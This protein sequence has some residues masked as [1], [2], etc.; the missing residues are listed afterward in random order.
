MKKYNIYNFAA[1]L[2]FSTS[3]LLAMEGDGSE[4]NEMRKSLSPRSS[5]EINEYSNFAFGVKK[6]NEYLFIGKKEPGLFFVM[7]RVDLSVPN[8]RLD[9]WTQYVL[10]EK[11]NHDRYRQEWANDRIPNKEGFIRFESRFQ[12]LN[13]GL[14]SFESSVK[15]HNL[16]N[17]LWIAY[18]SAKEIQKADEITPDDVEMM[19]TILTDKD[20]PMVIHMGITRC[21]HYLLKAMETE[22]TRESRKKLTEEQRQER[23]I[24]IPSEDEFKLHGSLSMGLHSFA[25][26]V[27][28]IRDEKKLYMITAPVPKMTEIMLK[29]LPAHVYVGTPLQIASDTYYN[30]RKDTDQILQSCLIFEE[31][32]KLNSEMAILEK[33]KIQIGTEEL[34]NEIKEKKKESDVLYADYR[35][36]QKKE[37]QEIAETLEMTKETSPIKNTYFPNKFVIFDKDRKHVVFEHDKDSRTI[38]VNNQEITGD[39]TKRYDWFYHTDMPLNPY[40]TINLDALSACLKLSDPH[41]SALLVKSYQPGEET[42]AED[43]LKKG[44]DVNAQDDGGRTAL[45]WA[46]TVGCYDDQEHNLPMIK[47][48]LA[49]KADPNKATPF[50][51]TPL[52][53]AAKSGHIEVA[54]LLLEAGAKVNVQTTIG[55][56]SP[57]DNAIEKGHTDMVNL[58]LKH[59]AI[60]VRFY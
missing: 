48:L 33:N 56:Y 23:G 53:Q 55:K 22:R 58:L 38:K 17:E 19:V 36:Q 30:K 12:N 18:T 47:L 7:E 40:V 39:E 60:S 44:V 27:M 41:L 13:G 20:S 3:S 32:Q 14:T 9:F 59:G 28:R 26:K 52:H 1:A 2:L 6:V 37:I 21:F 45:Y 46:S 35:I 16:N 15:N 31:W 10:E 8:S 50:G 43:L 54:S 25:A 49:Y 57:L 11:K 24:T 5:P 34:E 42:I 4:K 29:A 51:R